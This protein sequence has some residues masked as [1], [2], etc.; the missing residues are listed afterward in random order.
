MNEYK[1]NYPNAI[2]YHEEE[3]AN[4]SPLEK[5][6]EPYLNNPNSFQNSSSLTGIVEQRQQNAEGQSLGA[7]NSEDIIDQSNNQPT[8]IC[9]NKCAHKTKIT[10]INPDEETTNYKTKVKKTKDGKI[11]E[12]R[13]HRVNHYGSVCLG[14]IRK[15]LNKICGKYRLELK[16]P[17][18]QKLFSINSLYSAQFMKAKI[19]QIFMEKEG[20]R[21]VINKMVSEIKDIEFI[22]IVNLTFGF[23]CEYY[24][25]EKKDNGMIIDEKNDIAI[26]IF[27]TI[28][29]QIIQEMEM[30]GGFT[31]EKI[32]EEKNA[33]QHNSKKFFEELEKKQSRKPKEPEF[34][35]EVS[36]DI[37]NYF[38]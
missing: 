14:E 9:K 31:M 2:P 18:F 13:E 1:K 28:S 8:S 6:I 20:N 3:S 12:R 24:R 19:Y 29:E 7:Q 16:A 10:T 4:V 36:S 17:N 11:K 34:H 15:R 33:L 32:Q 5:E 38:K 21:E 35:F 27:E 23:I 25:K 26:K 22:Y 37:E 30:I